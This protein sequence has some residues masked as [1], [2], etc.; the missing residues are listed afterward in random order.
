M[1]GASGVGG[2]YGRPVRLQSRS[3]LKWVG[4]DDA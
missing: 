3:P 2:G 4:G 1:I